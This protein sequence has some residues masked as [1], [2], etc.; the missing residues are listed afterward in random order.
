[1]SGFDELPVATQY[2]IDG[3]LTSYFPM[4]LEEVERAEPIYETLPGWSGDLRGAR[5]FSELPDNCRRY[6]D[7]I[8][9]KAETPAAF[10]SVGPGRDE[11]IARGNPLA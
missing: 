10:L 7:Y 11:T 3:K 1:L 8:E 5:E 9:Q 2:R 6:V 4:T